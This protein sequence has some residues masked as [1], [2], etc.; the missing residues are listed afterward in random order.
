[1]REKN[2]S[3]ILFKYLQGSS[4]EVMYAE[5]VGICVY[6]ITDGEYVKIGVSNSLSLRIS[7]LQIG[8]PRELKP[9]HVIPVCD[10]REALALEKNLHNYFSKKKIRGEWFDISERDILDAKR[11][12]SYKLI[13]PVFKYKI[14]GN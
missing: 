13:R 5:D 8:N 14:S 4:D 7:H 11:M 9:L 12:F 10:L 3:L 1:M 2:R 6:F